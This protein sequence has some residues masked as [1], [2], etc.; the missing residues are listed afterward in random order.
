LLATGANDDDF[1]HRG[2]QRDSFVMEREETYTG[3]LAAV[4]AV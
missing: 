1:L 2:Q 3:V 4:T